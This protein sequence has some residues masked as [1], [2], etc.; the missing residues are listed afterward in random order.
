MKSQSI[1]GE[2]EYDLRRLGLYKT[3]SNFHI[4]IVFFLVIY[5]LS[6]LVL[7]FQFIFCVLIVSIKEI[8]F[9]VRILSG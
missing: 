3:R 8:F 6:F 2:S 4:S 5:F 9:I 1:V 7:L